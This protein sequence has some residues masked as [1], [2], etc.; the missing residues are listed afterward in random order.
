MRKLLSNA[1]AVS[2]MMSTTMFSTALAAGLSVDALPDL[3]SELNGHVTQDGHN[4]NVQV[5]EGLG[6]VGEFKWNSFNVGKNASVNFEFT[7]H[8]QTALNIVDQTGG[9]SQ[10]YGKLTNSGCSGCGYAGTGKVILLNPNGVMFGTGANVNLNSFTVSSF[11]GKYDKDKKELTLTRQAGAGDITVM[12]GANIHGNE[13]VNFAATNVNV[14]NGSKISTDVGINNFN[15]NKESVGKVK[16]VTADGV[17]FGYYGSGAVKQVKDLKAASDRM[18]IQ[19]NGD[20]EAGNIDVRN[21]SNNTN[22]QLNVNGANLKAVKAVKG[23]D[24]NIWLTSLNN[25]IVGDTTITTVNAQGAENTTD[26]GDVLIQAANKATLA[27]HEKQST[28]DAVGNVTITSSK[29]DVVVDNAKVNAAKSININAENIAAVQNAS[30]VTAKGDVT[31]YGKER[32]QVLDNSKVT[33]SKVKLASDKYVWTRGNSAIVSRSGDVD[34]EALN[35]KIVMKNTT[36]TAENNHDVNLKSAESITST[37]LAGSTFTGRNVN[38]TSTGDSVL[39]TSTNQFKPATEGA[40]NLKGAKNVEIN[41]EGALNLKDKNYKLNAGE[42]IFL[43]S[44]NGDVDI[45]KHVTFEN[46]QNIYISSANDLNMNADMNG[47]K[48]NL[49][50]ARDM[51][52][53]LDNV[54]VRE[55][56]LVAQAGHDMT[57]TTDGDLS[58]SRLV[59]GNDM[60]LTAKRVLSGSPKTTEKLKE[61]GDSSDRAYIEVGG[62]FTSNPEFTVTES[63]DRVEEDGK[64]YDRRH[65]IYYQNGDEAQEEIL[66]VNKREAKNVKPDEPDL[67][68]NPGSD[69]KNPI[70]PDDDN[71]SGSVTPPPTEPTDPNPTDPD[72]SKPTDPTDPDCKDEEGNEVV[73]PEQKP[74]IPG[75]EGTQG[76]GQQQGGNQGSEE[77]NPSVPDIDSGSDKDPEPPQEPDNTNPGQDQDTDKNQKEDNEDLG[78]GESRPEL[79]GDSESK[80]PEIDSQGD[81]SPAN[82]EETGNIK[83]NL[84][85]G[86]YIIKMEKRRL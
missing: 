7:S 83:Y 49:K 27:G 50:A 69:D 62:T 6:N 37:R 65:H 82:P 47:L 52:A 66:L 78:G 31:I 30:E 53:V 77:T 9:M 79:P 59:S 34:V 10:I 15:N 48:T 81:K 58:V 80:T 45:D 23:S 8:N 26:G 19:L 63:A 55:N 64:Y 86:S 42:N 11:D 43:T 51:N 25:V 38:L 33:G 18:I 32:A 22:S 56:G 12:N 3:K 36:V 35:G 61:D 68:T 14:Y 70:D 16:I 20:I 17:T 67:P 71:G 54:G 39:L 75:D 46:A 21:Y 28:V 44:K 57:I 84:D 13:A 85:N 74:T 2:V 5:S 72:P 1:L 29:T 4:M 40:L 41:T 73:T 60:T 76:G 24:G